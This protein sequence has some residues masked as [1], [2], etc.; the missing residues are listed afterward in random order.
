MDNARLHGPCPERL[1]YGVRE[2]LEAVLDS[3]RMV[4]QPHVLKL[5]PSRRSQNFGAS[6]VSDPKPKKPRARHFADAKGP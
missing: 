6:V 2:T 3:I 5:C 1:Q 4:L